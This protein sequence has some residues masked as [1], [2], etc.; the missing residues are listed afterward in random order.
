[1]ETNEN[2]DRQH[3]TIRDEDGIHY[4]DVLESVDF[5]YAAKLTALNAATLASLAAAPGVPRDVRLSGANS[6]A[7][8]LSWTAP[9]D[10]L[11]V[12]GYRVYWRLTDSPTWDYSTWVGNVTEYT[13]EGR[14]VD[15]YFF[16]VAAV[17]EDG[18]ESTVVFPL[19]RPRIR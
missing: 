12:A 19:P 10:S 16:G 9:D 17:A 1:M 3:Q 15:N 2:Y 8:R 11:N 6:P 14:V 4:G 18:S 7:A 5:D 13:F